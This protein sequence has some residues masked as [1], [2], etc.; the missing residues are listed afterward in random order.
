MIICLDF[1]EHKIKE[2]LCKKLKKKRKNLDIT[3]FVLNRKAQ[4]LKQKH[5][6]GK[7]ILRNPNDSVLYKTE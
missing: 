5:L 3:L 4:L 2:K 1:F 7:T 6:F